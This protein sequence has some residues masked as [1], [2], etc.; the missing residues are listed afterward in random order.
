MSTIALSMV[1][2]SEASFCSVAFPANSAEAKRAEAK[3]VVN[4][5]MFSLL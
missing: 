4:I 3:V 5:F 1:L 2:M